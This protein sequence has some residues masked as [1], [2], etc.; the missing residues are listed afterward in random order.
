MAS[1]NALGFWPGPLVGVIA[2]ILW[3]SFWTPPTLDQTQRRIRVS[4][5]TLAVWFAPALVPQ[6]DVPMAGA[7]LGIL[8]AWVGALALDRPRLGQA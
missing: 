6:R 2:C 7:S 1:Q 8:V 3:R 4:L 5:T